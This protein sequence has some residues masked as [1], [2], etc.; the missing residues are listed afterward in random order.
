MAGGRPTKYKQEMC[1]QVIDAMAQGLS[2]EAAAAEIGICDDTFH[3]WVKEI[4]EFSDAVKEGTRQNL[5]F[6]EKLGLS[7]ATGALSG[8]NATTWI[9]NMKNRFGWSDKQQV[10]TNG[11]QNVT[12]GWKQ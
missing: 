10:E 1:Q 7:G 9:F 8:F 4:P 6:W 11:N 3:R 2:K 12:F 5:L